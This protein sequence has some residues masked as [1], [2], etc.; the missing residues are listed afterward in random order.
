MLVSKQKI[1]IRDI[2]ALYPDDIHSRPLPQFM[3]NC[4][5]LLPLVVIK[6][7]RLNNNTRI[8]SCSATFGQ[9]AWVD[10]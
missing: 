5:P 9:G 4:K 6:S 8:C 2:D 10:D 7:R 3:C 1:S